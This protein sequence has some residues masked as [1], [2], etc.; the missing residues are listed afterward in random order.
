MTGADHGT[1]PGR[2]CRGGVGRA[3][4]GFM[5]VRGTSFTLPRVPYH[6]EARRGDL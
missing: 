6:P 3:D 5:V 1:W 4:G 2:A